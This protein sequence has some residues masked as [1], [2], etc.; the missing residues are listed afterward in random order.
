MLKVCGLTF[1]LCQRV[2]C[3]AGDED[4]VVARSCPVDSTTAIDVQPR[5]A[6]LSRVTTRGM[7]WAPDVAAALSSAYFAADA[8]AGTGASVCVATAASIVVIVFVV[9][10]EEATVYTLRCN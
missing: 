8:G 2:V 10:D 7:S 4:W 6:G 1:P 5:A 9:S 3:S